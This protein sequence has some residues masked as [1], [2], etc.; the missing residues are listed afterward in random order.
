VDLVDEQHV[1]LDQ[2]GQHRGQVAGAF[3]R[4]PDVTRNAEPS[5]AAMIIASDVLPS[6]GGPDSRM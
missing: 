6:P 3:Q 4:G 5:S 1:M 2:V